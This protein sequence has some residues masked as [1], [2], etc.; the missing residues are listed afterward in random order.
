[1]IIQDYFTK[2]RTEIKHCLLLLLTCLLAY[3]PL[4]FG[5]FSVKND[6]IHYFLP[7]RF[8]I[9]EAL[10]NGE[11]P[12]WSP[13]IYTGYPVQGDMQSGAW[14]PIVWLFS[15]FG[16]YDLTLFHFENLLYIFLA[17]VGM[18]KLTYQ[19]TGHART[20]LLTGMAWML[21]GF[22]LSGQLIN[23][24]AAAAFIPF[25]IHYYLLLMKQ[26]K[27]SNA[28]KTGFF[29]YLLF[30]AGY[31]SFFIL[32]GYL[33]AA[34][35]LIALRD[36]Y[37]HRKTMPARIGRFVGVHLVML[38]VFA[39]LALPA[40]VS[41][42]DLLPYYQRGAGASYEETVVNSFDIRHLSTLL[43]PA[44]I[45][46][47]D[48]ASVTDITCRNIYIGIIPL[49][50]LIALPP[51]RNRRTVLLTLLGL[52]TLL[53][54]LGDATPLRKWCFDLVPLMDTFRHPS[55]ARLFFMLALLL[56]AAPGLQKVVSRTWTAADQKR[57]RVALYV[58]AVFT[59]AVLLL[60]FTKTTLLKNADGG[61]G[62][63]DRI[64]LLL[65][66]VSLSDTLVVNGL[67]QLAFIILL[68]FCY[69]RWVKAGLFFTGVWVANLFIM[70]QLVLPASFVSRMGPSVL[71]NIIH[72]SPKGFPADRLTAPVGGNDS[73]STDMHLEEAV[74]YPFY[75][76]EIHTSR[77]TNSP[78]F[79]AATDSFVQ[80]GRL[81]KYVSA[82]PAV[83]APEIL[84]TL[85]DTNDVSLPDHSAT[86]RYAFRNYGSAQPPVEAAL[87]KKETVITQ[88]SSNTI[89]ISV[90]L[91]HENMV[92]LTQAYHHSWKAWVD[93]RP[94]EIQRMNIAFMGVTVPKGSH[95][96]EFRFVPVNTIRAL[97]V[98][99]A[100]ALILLFSALFLFI[101]RKR[102]EPK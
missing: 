71:N 51:K 98:Q 76:K 15:L 55:Q 102:S 21:S 8:H 86:V 62:I 18:Y 87:G 3:W 4:T 49:L 16:R 58:A 14:N 85:K 54:S 82:M 35:S 96:V 66:S 19:L 63:K 40:I 17:G 60:A 23:W 65:D 91:P 27:I 67:L 89:T 99:V 50:L 95:V 57:V 61:G 48:M 100:T 32:T 22:M 59:L 56:L 1:M 25:V 69:K 26:G 78:A 5:I 2:N 47:N 34:L 73:V 94:T 53:F 72:A 80:T 37:V 28:I 52:F 84:L 38:V 20:A 81:Y 42:I 12:F 9:S 29:L 41:Y 33:M 75:S 97:W 6:A 64:K 10:R 68:L 77:I 7:Y 79:L 92:V 90:N 93:G 11:M 101:K 44:T 46:A 70:A 13:Y 88:L 83:Y 30:T 31:P 74:M 36:K 45:K 43:Y 39:G 24:L